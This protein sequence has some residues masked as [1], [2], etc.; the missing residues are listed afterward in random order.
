MRKKHEGK[1]KQF[2]S[3]N[4]ARGHNIIVNLR[5][6]RIHIKIRIGVAVSVLV[7]WFQEKKKKDS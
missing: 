5:N 6:S 3:A 7:G 4:K 1:T 2:T